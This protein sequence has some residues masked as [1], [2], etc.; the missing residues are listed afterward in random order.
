MS[1]VPP[2]RRGGHFVRRLAKIKY[3]HGSC[4]FDIWKAGKGNG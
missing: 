1:Y 2:L 4:S 3:S